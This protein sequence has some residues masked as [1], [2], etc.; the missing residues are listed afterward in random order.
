MGTP[1]F[2]ISPL[3]ALLQTAH[4]VAGVYTQPDNKAGR[5]K[6]LTPSPVKSFSMERGLRV[7]EPRDLRDNN[8]RDQLSSLSPDLIVIAAYRKI[9]PKEILAIPGAF[10]IILSG[11]GFAIAIPHSGTGPFDLI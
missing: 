10:N 1:S 4:T 2:A 9:L 7:F 3:N 6:T 11:F 8:V 5:G